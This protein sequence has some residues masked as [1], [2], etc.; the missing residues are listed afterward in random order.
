MQETKQK[1]IIQIESMGI[2]NG[3]LCLIVNLDYIPEECQIVTKK[4]ISNLLAERD[5]EVREYLGSI[6][7]IGIYAETKDEILVKQISNYLE[8][9]RQSLMEKEDN[10]QNKD[11]IINKLYGK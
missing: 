9:A 1:E 5:A 8:R 7:G 11:D 2:V 4:Y 10:K 3:K 6:Y